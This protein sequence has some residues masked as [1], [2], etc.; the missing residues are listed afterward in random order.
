M[1]QEDV[2]IKLQLVGRN[3][4]TSNYS[5]IERGIKN[6]YVSD[7]MLFKEIFGTQYDEFFKDL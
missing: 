7:L 4:S 5:Q 6:I 2:I 1:T 3:M